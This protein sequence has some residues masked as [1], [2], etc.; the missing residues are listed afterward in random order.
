MLH[1]RSN[2]KIFDSLKLDISTSITKLTYIHRN[3]S[4]LFNCIPLILGNIIKK[5]HFESP[6]L[7]VFLLDIARIYSEI[8]LVVLLQFICKRI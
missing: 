4:P 5:F 3:P 8:M 7:S 1:H 6:L 2:K